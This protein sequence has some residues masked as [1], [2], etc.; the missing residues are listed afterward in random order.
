MTSVYVIGTRGVPNR[1]GGFERLVEVLAPDLVRRGYDVTVFCHAAEEQQPSVDDWH[2]VRRVHLRTRSWGPLSTLEYDLR[3]IWAVPRGAVALIFGYG[4]AVFQVRLR[5]LG[6]RHCVNMDGIEW[7]RQKWSAGAKLWLRLNE[8]IAANLSTLLVADHPEIQ[9]YLSRAFGVQSRMIAYGV[10]P[11]VPC[12]T[13]DHPLL[14]GLG[15][16]SFDLVIARPE[17]E[18]QLHVVLEAHKRSGTTLPLVI[19]GNMGLNE[20]GRQLMRDNPAAFFVGPIYDVSVLNTLRGS[21]NLYLH[22][23]SVGG[24]N[25][26]LIEAMAAGAVIVAHDN[27]FNRWVASEGALYFKGADDLARYFQHRVDEAQRH[28]LRRAA[29][30]ACLARFSWKGILDAYAEVVGNLSGPDVPERGQ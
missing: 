4:T 8:R 6:I 29:A 30:E 2:G 21:A 27:V 26:S 16:G 9:A 10:D 13:P 25:P 19:V 28:A 22:G 24:T 17:P 3:S 11:S 1:Y 18:N 7:Q 14:R 23:H 20:Y 5:S 12:A 15:V